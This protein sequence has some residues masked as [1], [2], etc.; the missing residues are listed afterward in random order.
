[1]DRWRGQTPP[2]LDLIW[3]FPI[4]VGDSP[5]R[6]TYGV[7]E[8]ELYSCCW[9]L[10]QISCC[11]LL[12]LLLSLLLSCCYFPN[13]ASLTS[14]YPVFFPGSTP[15]WRRTSSRESI[16]VNAYCTP[17]RERKFPG[18]SGLFSYSIDFPVNYRCEIVSGLSTVR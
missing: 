15:N 11:M 2:W 1:M 9:C 8:P 7:E 17:R 13:I 10:C 5:A 6:V 12:S 4:E 18:S 3:T 14:H 16:N